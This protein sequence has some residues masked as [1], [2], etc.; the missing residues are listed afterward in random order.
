MWD[1]IRDVLIVSMNKAQLPMLAAAGLLGIAL[2]RMPP[3][4]VSRLM[5]EVKSD[6]VHERLLGYALTVVVTF[7]WFLHARAQ[8]R[9]IYPE[10]D[11]IGSEKTRLQKKQLGDD[12]ESSG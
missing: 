12:L 6:L 2:L 10:I 3:G 9:T 1:M 5:F 7:G 11:R 4:D 8:R